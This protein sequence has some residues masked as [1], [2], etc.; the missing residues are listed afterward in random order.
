M[1]RTDAAIILCAVALIATL[2]GAV[3]SGGGT[4]RTA[5]VQVAG[6]RVASLD[7]DRDT[8][9]TVDGPLG[10][11]RVEVADHR[12]RVARS[13][14]QRQLCVRRGWLEQPGEQVV[15]LPNRVRVALEGGADT[16]LDAITH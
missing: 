14:G 11:T 12:V 6:E 3:W 10:T 4:P 8:T 16:Q 7:L 5:T 2:A 9:I 1:T 13:P 15:C